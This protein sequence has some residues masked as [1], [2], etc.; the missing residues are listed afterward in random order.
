MCDIV[1][2][3]NFKLI[4]LLTLILAFYCDGWV[5][6]TYDISFVCFFVSY[7]VTTGVVGLQRIHFDSP[8]LLQGSNETKT[9]ATVTRHI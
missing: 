6:W 4:L 5:A 7:T 2:F 9:Q 8:H 1:C 3:F